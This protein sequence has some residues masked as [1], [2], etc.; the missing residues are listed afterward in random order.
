MDEKERKRLGCT[1]DRD[2]VLPDGK[3]N[4]VLQVQN[5]KIDAS[6]IFALARKKLDSK[7]K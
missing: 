3:V 7:E 4:H 5:L 1:S 2:I 6:M